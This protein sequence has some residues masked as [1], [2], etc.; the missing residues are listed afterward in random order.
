VSL[1]IAP[2]P[3]RMPAQK[4]RSAWLE[5]PSSTSAIQSRKTIVARAPTRPRSATQAIPTPRLRSGLSDCESSSP[6]SAKSPS[7]PPSSSSAWPKVRR[8][9]PGFENRWKTWLIELERKISSEYSPRLVW[10]SF[11]A[12]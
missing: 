1:K 12:T 9:V 3:P 6:F 4:M 7:A 11:A 10:P 2:A 5:S 8:S